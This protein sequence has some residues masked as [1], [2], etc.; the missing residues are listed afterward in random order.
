MGRQFP[1][2]SSTVDVFSALPKGNGL[3]LA[4]LFDQNKKPTESTSRTR[5][6]IGQGNSNNNNNSINI[7]N[8][9]NINNSNNNNNNNNSNN[10]LYLDLDQFDMVRWLDFRLEPIFVTVVFPFKMVKIDLSKKELG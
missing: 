5:E 8:S 6:K 4:S 9:N 1:V 7:S 2:T 10:I 3:C